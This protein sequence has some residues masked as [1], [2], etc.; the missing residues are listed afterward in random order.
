M[1]QAGYVDI[2]EHVVKVSFVIFSGLRSSLGLKRVQVPVRKW[3]KD[4]KLRGLG[5][6]THLSLTT[7]VE[8][9]VTYMANL[10]G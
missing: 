2:E 1:E 6:F 7:D 5:H 8:G 9:I 3:P 10:Q 4:P